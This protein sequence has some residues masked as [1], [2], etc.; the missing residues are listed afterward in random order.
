MEQGKRNRSSTPH[1]IEGQGRE[2]LHSRFMQIEDGLVVN[3]V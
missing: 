2:V 1:R 3:R